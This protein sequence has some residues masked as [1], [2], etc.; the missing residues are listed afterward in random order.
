MPAGRT[1]WTRGQPPQRSSTMLSRTKQARARI[2]RLRLALLSPQ[3][4]EIAAAI[5]GLEQAALCLHAVEQELLDGAIA[6]PA[7]R[8]ELHML[9]NDLRISARLVEQ[10]MA[11]CRGWAQML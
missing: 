3:P 9:K 11:F 6:P 4:E 5:P 1:R 2:E 7:V 8:R 10:G